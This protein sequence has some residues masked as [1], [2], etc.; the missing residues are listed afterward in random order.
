MTKKLKIGLFFGGRSTEHEVSVV[1]AL[2]AYKNI[3]KEKYEVIP[4]YVSKSGQFFFSPKLLDLKNY[5]DLNKL[6]S[7]SAKETLTNNEAS[8]P[9]LLEQKLIPKFK[10]LDLAFPLFHGSFGEDGCIQGLFEMFQIPYVGLGVMGSSLAMDK[11]TSKALFKELGF[12]TA[13]YTYFS[14]FQWV[15]DSKK[16]LE[17]IQKTLKFPMVV[18]PATLGST[19]GISKVKNEDDLSFAIEVASTYCQKILIEEAFPDSFIEVNCS[20]LG[21][22]DVQ[23]SVC[24]MPVKSEELLSYADKYMRGG[25]K[26]TGSSAGGME[27]LSR[28]IPAPIPDKLTKQIQDATVTI[29]NALDGCGVTRTDFFVDKKNNRFYVN[30]VN[31]PPGSLAFYLWEKTG[32]KYPELLDKLITYALQRAEDQ[33]NTQYTFDSGLLEQ[34]ALAGGSGSKR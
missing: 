9:G 27:T 33:K 24:E 13:Q 18:K 3:D 14:R 29:F 1:S 7:A 22:K 16:V 6:L 5:K 15:R 21:Y 8:G 20:A 12:S 19:I 30:E 34:M 4:I 26:K 10:P 32:I 2:Q 11:V 28:V 31:S 17:Q 23:A 25:G